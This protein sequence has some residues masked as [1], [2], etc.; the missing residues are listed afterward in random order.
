MT[1]KGSDQTAQAGLSLCRLHIPHCWKSHVTVDFCFKGCWVVSIIF[2]QILI[3]HSVSK[4][5]RH[6]DQMLHFGTSDL[7]L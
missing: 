1:S 4:Q 5:W 3:D 2:I 6:L 7:D